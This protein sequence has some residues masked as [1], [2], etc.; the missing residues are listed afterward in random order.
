VSPVP[1]HKLKGLMV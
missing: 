1:H